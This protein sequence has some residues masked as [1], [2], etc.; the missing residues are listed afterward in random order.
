MLQR[1][2][3]SGVPFGLLTSALMATAVMAASQGPVRAG[4]GVRGPGEPVVK[5]EA[6]REPEGSKADRRPARS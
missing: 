6:R 4:D 2:K 1:H 5:V 3:F